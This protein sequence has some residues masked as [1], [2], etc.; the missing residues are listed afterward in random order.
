MSAPVRKSVAAQTT[1]TELVDLAFAYA[2]DG[3]FHSA[4]RCLREAADRFE[5]RGKHIEKLLAASGLQ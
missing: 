2:G 5:E 3:A 1:V 4:A